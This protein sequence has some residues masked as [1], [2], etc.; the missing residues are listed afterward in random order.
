MKKEVVLVFQRNAVLGKVKTRLAS[1]L[2]EHRALEIYKHLVQLTYSALEEVPLPIWTFFSDFI[3]ESTH[4]TVERSFVQQGQDLGERMANAF[5]HTFDSGV[6]KVVLIGTDCPSLQSQHLLQA[7]EA[8]D[9][10]DLVLGPAYDGG[11]YLIGMKSRAAYL[12]EGIT[13]STSQ[14]LSQTLQVAS[15]HGLL[16]TLLAVLADMDTLE[17][18]QRYSRQFGNMI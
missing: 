2:G 5:A 10:S 11:Y 4:P 6:G 3:P 9:H 13:W 17:D 15:Q 14:V 8:L 1:G 18:W 16:V 12:F 7:V